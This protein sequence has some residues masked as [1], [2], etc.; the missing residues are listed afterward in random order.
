MHN[1]ESADSCTQVKPVECNMHAFCPV[2][3]VRHKANEPVPAITQAKRIHPGNRA[4]QVNPNEPSSHAYRMN[5]ATEP[6]KRSAASFAGRRSDQS[7]QSLTTE[8]QN[9]LL[10][11][12][13]K[14]FK[15]NRLTLRSISLFKASGTGQYICRNSRCHTGLRPT[16]RRP[17]P[18]PCRS[19]ST[20]SPV[21]GSFACSGFYISIVHAAV[22][23][24]KQAPATAGGAAE[25][26]LLLLS[27]SPFHSPSSELFLTLLTLRRTRHQHRGH[28]SLR[29]EKIAKV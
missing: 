28:E 8:K 25:G 26:S 12:N 17:L 18:P 1:R 20:S 7:L 23:D 16:R 13:S 15:S 5:Q 4:R 11:L 10:Y 6:I 22:A 3:P 27:S 9:D 2:S 14:W 21:A 29:S 19:L 24:G